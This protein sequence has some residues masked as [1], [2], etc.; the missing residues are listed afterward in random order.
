MCPPVHFLHV[1]ALHRC[2][3]CSIDVTHGYMCASASEMPSFHMGLPFEIG[4]LRKA[5]PSPSK[6]LCTTNIGPEFD[7]LVRPMC[8]RSS[9]HTKLVEQSLDRVLVQPKPVWQIPSCVERD[10]CLWLCSSG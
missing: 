5:V 9:Q 3:Q 8:M 1:R 4:I 7:V 10:M 2:L 6:L